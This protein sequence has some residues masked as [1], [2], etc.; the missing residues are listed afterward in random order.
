[1]GGSIDVYRRCAEELD[2]QLA[3]WAA[4]LTRECLPDIGP[5]AAE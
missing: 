1:M 3:E 5:A 4:R 2:A